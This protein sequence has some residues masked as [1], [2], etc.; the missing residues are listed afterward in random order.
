MLNAAGDRQVIRVFAQQAPAPELGHEPHAVRQPRVVDLPLIVKTHRVRVLPEIAEAV[1]VLAEQ[2]RF[3]AV[4]RGIHVVRAAE[5]LC[6]AAPVV[7]V[8][9]DETAGFEHGHD[10]RLGR[11][12]VLLD[13][14]AGAAQHL[15]GVVGPDRLAGC[16]GETQLLLHRAGTPGFA[17]TKPVDAPG[18]QVLR[19][20]CGRHH[21]AGDVIERVNA[22]AGEPVVEPHGVVAG[23]EGLGE[24][25]L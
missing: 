23:G 24:G 13:K 2:A 10:Q 15:A 22:L 6:G 3:D 20:L 11:V 12:G 1:A 18:L 7:V 25:Q 17:D 8:L 5:Q 4:K 14:F 21:H 19:H 16:H 9:F